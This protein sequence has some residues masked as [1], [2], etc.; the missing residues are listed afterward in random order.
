[1][2]KILSD[3]H[4]WS[5]GKLSYINDIVDFAIRIYSLLITI[6]LL[7]SKQNVPQEIIANLNPILLITL[8]IIL[9][10]L[11]VIAF[12]KLY[13]ATLYIINSRIDENNISEIAADYKENILLPVAKIVPPKV[14]IETLTVELNRQA[15]RWSIDSEVAQSSLEIWIDKNEIRRELKIIFY[16]RRKQSALT[17]E[18][19][20]LKL[21][22]SK[23][24]LSQI[25]RFDDMTLS[26]CSASFKV[27]EIFN[28]RN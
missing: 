6:V 21:N 8:V 28:Q 3:I 26:H 7:P 14:V 16:S 5:S 20:S 24:S 2:K 25:R 15:K 13:R 11:T 4:R 23:I 9:I 22:K 10:T 19:I 18:T 17:L 12:I 1:M 27:E